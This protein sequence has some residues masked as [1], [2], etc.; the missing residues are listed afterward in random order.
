AAGGEAREGPSIG[1]EGPWTVSFQAERGA[2]QRVE[3][4]RLI[5]WTAHPNPG[6]KY[7]AGTARYAAA[8]HVPAGWRLPGRRV[9]LDLGR[10]WTIGEAWLN[11]RPLG[12][13]WT[14]PFRADCTEGLKEGENELVVEVTN[15]WYNRLIGDALLPAE[16]RITRTNLTT[17]GGTPWSKLQPLESGLFGPVR[18]V[19]APAK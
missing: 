12:V 3:F 11:G 5:S 1:I 16:R 4:P 9:E 15:T 14:A 7:F 2:P 17:S 6:V 10:L 18:I 13:V 8:F 19:A